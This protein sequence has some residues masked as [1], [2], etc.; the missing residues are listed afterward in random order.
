MRL[1]RN[2][3]LILI[4]GLFFLLPRAVYAQIT[5]SPAIDPG[6]IPTDLG[7]VPSDVP[8]F[9]AK[10]YQYGLGIIGGVTVLFIILGSYIILTSRGNPQQ[11]NNGKAYI[12]YALTGLILAIFGYLFVEVIARDL[13]RIPGFG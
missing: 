6:C 5:P 10:Y 12:A 8:S 1:T 7:C 9:V 13:L 2:I 3:V 11:L 4:L